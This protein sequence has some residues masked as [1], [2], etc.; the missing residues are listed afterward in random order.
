MNR[1]RNQ[2]ITLSAVLFI[3]LLA[4]MSLADTLTSTHKGKGKR[5]LSSS[6]TESVSYPSKNSFPVDLSV[7]PDMLVIPGGAGF[8]FTIHAVTPVIH[9][10]PLYVGLETGMD[11]NAGNT[12][13]AMGAGAAVDQAA[14]AGLGSI[15]D[16][17]TVMHLLATGVYRFDIVG[18][19][20][21]HPFVGVSMGP[22]L[23]FWK[24][25][26]IV[27]G[28]ATVQ[29][30]ALLRTGVSFDLTS[31]LALNVEPKIGVFG[32]DFMFKPVVAAAFSL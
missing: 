21:I 30:E 5:S 16:S 2:W 17:A 27:G 1:S 15:G 3:A 4:R 14:A 23:C 10:V 9:N 13:S 22:A 12:F 11:F 18:A 29:F 7:G 28:P 19:R 26:A 24:G 6:S 32:G 20:K 31:R 8:G 25:P